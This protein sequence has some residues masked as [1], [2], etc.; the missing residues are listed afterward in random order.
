MVYLKNLNLKRDAFLA[1]RPRFI[2]KDGTYHIMSMGMNRANIFHHDADYKT[3][4]NIL[5][6]NKKKYNIKI[7]HYILM[8]NHLHFIMKINDGK[9]L[10][11]T[12]KS[13]N[14][15]YSLYHHK[16]YNSEGSLFQDRYRSFIIQQG[17]YLLEAGR[18]LE[19]N[20][21]RAKVVDSSDKYKWSSYNIYAKG[22][23]S[24]LIDMNPEYLK[25]D[26]DSKKRQILYKKF[27]KKGIEWE[28]RR[29]DRFFKDGAYG[30]KDFIESLTK[31]GLN[32]VWSHSGRPRKVKQLN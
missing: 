30:S 25:L 4:L 24:D 16:T 14:I 9:N 11:N 28:R 1:R 6:A 29:E 23:K 22:E 31:E 18:Y 20:P 2:I 32:P 13:Q 15:K 12:I 27:V 19:L 8:P 5:Y 21:V 10:G 3:Y 26:K 17:R 7:Y